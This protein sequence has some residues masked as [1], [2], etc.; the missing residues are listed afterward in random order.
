[1]VN[2]LLANR[3]ALCQASTVFGLGDVLRK[4]R[5]KRKL[6][7]EQLDALTGINKGT[8]SALE[9]GEGNPTVQTLTTLATALDVPLYVLFQPP[10][11]EPG[12]VDLEADRVFAALRRAWAVPREENL[13][14]ALRQLAERFFYEEADA[15]PAHRP[16]QPPPPRA[17]TTNDTRPRS[18]K[19]QPR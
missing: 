16:R 1:M 7:L 5:K 4:Y 9:R 10:A 18:R 2:G 8:I 12:E 3:V 6:S 19:S 15:A 11:G 14:T 17:S 13:R